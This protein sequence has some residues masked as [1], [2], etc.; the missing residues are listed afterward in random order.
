MLALSG[1]FIF[2]NL[3]HNKTLIIAYILAAIGSPSEKYQCSIPLTITEY[4]STVISK[5][6]SKTNEMAIATA[7]FICIHPFTIQVESKEIFSLYSIHIVT[8]K[9]YFVKV[10]IALP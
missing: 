1:L 9:I 2:K 10:I 4:V 7:F 8:W 5:I 3:T 6:L